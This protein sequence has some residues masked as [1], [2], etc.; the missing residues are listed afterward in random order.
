MKGAPRSRFRRKYG[1]DTSDRRR[2]LAQL[3]TSPCVGGGVHAVAATFTRCQARGRVVARQTQPEYKVKGALPHERFRCRQK[4]SQHAYPD[5]QHGRGN[6]CKLDTP[7]QP[8]TRGGEASFPKECSGRSYTW[9]RAQLPTV[10]MT[11]H[12]RVIFER[13]EAPC[14]TEVQDI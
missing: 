5:R 11:R 9:G 12:N 10:H 1:F 7:T 13:H 6:P 8:P 3:T 2:R 14:R 4:Q